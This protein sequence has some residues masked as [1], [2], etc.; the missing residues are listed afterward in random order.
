MTEK[1][2]NR[3]GSDFKMVPFSPFKYGT[4]KK[5]FFYR[6]NIK[7]KRETV[8]ILKKLIKKLTF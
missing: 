7:E 5:Q 2:T 4:L 1:R 8:N 3:H 6:Q